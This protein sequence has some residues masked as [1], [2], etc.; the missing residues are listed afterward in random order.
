MTP[1]KPGKTMGSGLFSKLFLE[2][3]HE[4]HHLL[5]LFEL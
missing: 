2:G 1:G 4:H 3:D 5:E